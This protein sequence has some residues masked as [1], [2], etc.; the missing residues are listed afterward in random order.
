MAQ[1]ERRVSLGELIQ[2]TGIV[3]SSTRQP[4][5]SAP[6]QPSSLASEEDRAQA[7]DIL[8]RRRQKNPENKDAVLKRI[9]KSSKEKEKAL[10]TAQWEFSHD[11]LDQALSAIIRNPDPNP[12]LVSAFLEMGAR[13]N[14]VDASDK[15]RSMSNTS[16]SRPRRRSTV[17]QQ[18]AT[19]R[20]VDS[21]KLLAYSGA[22]QTTLDDGLRAAL[23]AKDQACIE[24]L[25]RYG[26]D[27]NRFPNTL[28]NAVQSNDQDLA[29]LL[30]RAP[31][32]LR[33]EIVSS[34][35]SAAVRQK[36]EPVASLL[37]AHG[38]DPNFDSAGALNMA[39]GQEDWKMSLTLVAGPIPLTPQNLQR[40]LD[41]VM[42]LRTCVATLQFLQLLFCC[43]LPPN[44]IG[45]PDLLICRVRKNDTPGSKMMINHGVPTTANDAE[46]LKLAIENQNWF[47]VDAILNTP[48]EAPHASAAL[49]LVF[50]P[51]GQ[52]HPRTL[53]LL[54][55]LLP[56]RTD[57]TSTLQILR[58]A[59]EGGP[60]NLDVVQRL[61]AADPKLLGP[62]F[63]YT[64]AL[65]DQSKKTALTEALLKL[66][67]PQE[68]EMQYTTSPKDLS[69]T[70]VL[71]R[72]EAS[73]SG[74]T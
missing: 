24:E 73:V 41:T 12:G 47:L 13:V 20:K 57:D 54:D 10:D 3:P 43:G 59:I 6:S 14:F 70:T 51:Q 72:Q 4:S 69:T 33:P 38:A 9:F 28:V 29:R 1:A 63:Q 45:L 71:M 35:L 68:A 46:C 5:L 19:L 66:G 11:E 40:L 42:R 53:A 37:I 8:I 27:L 67:I 31:K 32:A 60:E 34:C 16:N 52:R 36:S 23:V 44:S 50:N 17:L 74:L 22:D 48:V 49:P 2:A 58:I 25:L 64:A 56:Y 7:R 30:L 21:V 39:I 61:L 26:A 65:Q 15:K 62:A 55:I 18:A